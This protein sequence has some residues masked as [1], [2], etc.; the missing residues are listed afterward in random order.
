MKLKKAL[1][2]QIR[3]ILTTAKE[4]AIRSVDFERVMMFGK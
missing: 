4:R 1:I 3:E 2:L